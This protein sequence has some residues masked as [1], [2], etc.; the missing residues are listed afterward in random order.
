MVRAREERSDELRGMG[1]L[2]IR[3]STATR[4][5]CRQ[6]RSNVINT[7][8][9][10]RRSGD[11]DAWD[12]KEFDEVYENLRICLVATL[13]LSVEQEFHVSLAK[14][15]LKC[16][17][18]FAQD[19]E[20][21]L[22]GG[23]ACKI[24]CNLEKSSNFLV[25]NLIYKAQLNVA[26]LVSHKTSI[27][28]EENSQ[29]DKILIFGKKIGENKGHNENRNK[30]QSYLKGTLCPRWFLDEYPDADRNSTVRSAAGASA[31]R[32]LAKSS[33]GPLQRADGTI[34]TV[35]EDEL[36]LMGEE[37]RRRLYWT[38]TSNADTSVRDVAAASSTAVFSPIILRF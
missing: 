23:I 9:I 34:A 7:S 18:E 8:F 12:Y 2:E 35:E 4:F 29:Q 16:L 10:A 24:I 28:N 22:I 20:D 31:G 15:F 5:T 6:H 37:V 13:N 21:R 36:L 11:A 30:T 25:Q 26:S 17:V 27:I 38:S 1:V 3:H 32:S 19:D 33:L 14:R